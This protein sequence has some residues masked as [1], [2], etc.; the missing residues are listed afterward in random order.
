MSDPGTAIGHNSNITDE[1]K[2]KLRGYVEELEK[3]AEEAKELSERRSEIFKAAK[4]AFFDAKAI[5]HILKMR[6]LN[7]FDRDAF[8]AAV[9]AYNIALGDFV[10]TPLGQAMQPKEREF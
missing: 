8:E 6:K 9:D 1:Q 7:K 2:I 10:A 5:R 4:E 3:I